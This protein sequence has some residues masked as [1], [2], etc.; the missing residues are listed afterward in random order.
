MATG[1][2][3]KLPP[4]VKLRHTLEGHK[5]GVYGIAFDPIGSTGTLLYV[6]PS[7]QKAI[8]IFI[9]IEVDQ[10]RIDILRIGILI[11]T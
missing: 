2:S 5:S 8:S 1:K 3:Q 9:R 7:C 10:H 6:Y 4:G 11:E